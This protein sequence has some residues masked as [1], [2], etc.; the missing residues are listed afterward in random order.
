MKQLLAFNIGEINLGTG[1]NLETTYGTGGVSILVSAVLKYSL[2]LAGIILL[3]L[4]I[5]GGITVIMNAG[6]GDPKKAS[7][8]KSAIT[9]AAIGFAVVFLAYSIIKIIEVITGLNILESTL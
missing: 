6:K 5:F 1:K 7:Q 9:N 4:L 2:M 8:G 3:S